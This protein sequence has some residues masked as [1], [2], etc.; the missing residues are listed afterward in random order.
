MFLGK[1]GRYRENITAFILGCL[2]FIGTLNTGV[3]YGYGSTGTPIQTIDTTVPGSLYIS[4]KVS[5]NFDEKSSLG[6]E[7][8]D[9]RVTTTKEMEIP[10]DVHVTR[11]IF[12]NATYSFSSNATSEWSMKEF[13]VA[14]FYDHE[15]GSWVVFNGNV[16]YNIS[17][18]GSEPVDLSDNVNYGNSNDVQSTVGL[19]KDVVSKLQITN[20]YDENPDWKVTWYDIGAEVQ[21]VYVKFTYPSFGKL[22]L[23]YDEGVSSVDGLG[24]GDYYYKK[25]D[26]A[27]T[28]FT[29]K[30]G[31]ELD[32]IGEGDT[33]WNNTKWSETNKRYENSWT[34]DNDR[35]I[36]IH[37]K[38]IKYTFDVNGWLDGKDSGWI[39]GYGTYDLYI[40]GTRVADDVND[41]Y[42][43]NGI[44]YGSTYEITDIK[45]TKG[46]SYAGVHSGSIKGTVTGDTK[47]SLDFRTYYNDIFVNYYAN[48]GTG[49]N[50]FKSYNATVTNQYDNEAFS[51][52]GYT[53]KGYSE[54]ANGEVKHR[55]GD[56]I[57]A[58]S[59]QT[60]IRNAANTN[61]GIDIYAWENA[62]G[63]NLAAYNLHNGWNQQWA[64][65]YEKTENGVPYWTI[66]NPETGKV[67]DV[68][69]GAHN[70]S[71]VHLWQYHGGDNQLWTLELA[72]NGLVYIR[73]KLGNYYL[74]LFG[75]DIAADGQNIVIWEK[76]GGK[77]QKWDICDATINCYAHWTVNKYT[78]VFDSNKPADSTGNVT[79]SMSNIYCTYDEPV[80]IPENDFNLRGWD[81]VAWNTSADGSGT[82]YFPNDTVSNL[83]SIDGSTVTLYAEWDRHI[84]WIAT[85]SKINKSFINA[86]DL[87]SEDESVSWPAGIGYGIVMAN[88]LT[89]KEFGDMQGFL[90][91]DICNVYP[92]IIKYE[93]SDTR[94]N[95]IV[96]D[97]RVYEL[98]KVN[99]KSEFEYAVG[100]LSSR[101]YTQDIS[102]T[103]PEYEAESKVISD[104]EYS[105]Y[106]DISVTYQVYQTNREIT[107][108]RRV[109]YNV[110]ELDMSKIH[111]RIRRQPGQANN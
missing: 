44:T 15:L 36:Y 40:N 80:Q 17:K 6:I 68:A 88:T 70:G 18:S 78:I 32:Y 77:D 71:N 102:F 99:G 37:T 108:K 35:S 76:D 90:N 27:S 5:G 9:C 24:K 43:E 19:S 98:V 91:V 41:S 87:T 81:F 12:G 4:Y 29:L 28:N 89:Y 74:E 61:L 75:D 11:D 39:T 97:N 60:R 66:R 31:Y 103:L 57:Q 8:N 21:D 20:M 63:A 2:I 33:K 101:T 106:V 52:T 58:S 95:E 65:A 25:G 94:I 85:L 107:E 48:G 47:V 46:H 23:D 30:E 100:P 49:N 55:S 111:S 105:A 3:Q 86:K 93:F 34:M 67:I 38:P 45:V 82:R 84:E 10:I 79:G 51:R 54:T 50:Y 92:K 13:T 69:D 56:N 7:C 26:V 96:L 1:K 104:K 22:S 53:F 72:E 62:N 110:E 109:Y 73:S 83:T 42:I 59:G 14:P 16:S 64:F